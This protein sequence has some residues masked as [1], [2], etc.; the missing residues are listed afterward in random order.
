MLSWLRHQHRKPWLN[1]GKANALLDSLES[2]EF[3]SSHHLLSYFHFSG[4]SIFHIREGILLNFQS[5][6]EIL[7]QNDLSCVSCILYMN[8]VGERDCQ[9]LSTFSAASPP[10][11]ASGSLSIFFPICKG[12]ESGRRMNRLLCVTSL[13]LN[14]YLSQHSV[15]KNCCNKNDGLYT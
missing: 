15:R 10:R 2:W 13:S 3:T 4:S 7:G 9:R 8:Y 12:P 14:H 11:T 1:L 5:K 6:T